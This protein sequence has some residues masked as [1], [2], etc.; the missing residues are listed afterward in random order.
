[1]YFFQLYITLQ[2]L[3]THSFHDVLFQQVYEFYMVFNE[4]YNNILYTKHVL[5]NCRSSHRRCYIKKAVLKSFAICTGKH[6]NFIKKRLQH[7]CFPMN[8]TKILRTSIVRNICER[9]LLELYRDVW[10]H[11]N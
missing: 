4:S 11:V 8:T 6:C 2:E 7:R 1:M 5:M 10:S 9:L 3:I